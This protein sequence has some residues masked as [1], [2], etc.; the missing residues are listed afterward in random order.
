MPAKD[1]NWD[2]KKKI[3]PGEIYDV[4]PTK[5]K[6]DYTAIAKSLQASPETKQKALALAA[7]IAAHEELIASL[8]EQMNLAIDKRDND[9][10]YRDSLQTMNDNVL[11]LFSYIETNCSDAV[12]AMVANKQ[13]LFRG[14]N[15][16]KSVFIG[17]P[18]ENRKPKDSSVKDQQLFDELL[19]IAGFTAL[20][21]NSI[22][23]TASVSHASDFGN[24]YIIFPMNGFKF[25]WSPMYKD[26]IIREHSFFDIADNT[27]QIEEYYDSAAE[28]SRRIQI[29]TEDE[30]AYT[31][32]KSPGIA[33]KIKKFLAP[34]LSTFA[35]LRKIHYNYTGSPLNLTKETAVAY[36][37]FYDTCRQYSE[38]PNLPDS[39]KKQ[40]NVWI[41]QN[42]DLAEAAKQ[43]AAA[44]IDIIKKK[45]AN[46]MVTKH[47]FTN[48]NFGAALNV[49]NEIY[50][51]GKYVAID[52]DEFIDDALQYFIKARNKKG[53]K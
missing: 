31:H 44:N 16:T 33:S 40:F 50:V 35:E 28:F 23:C 2:F 41:K 13:L 5:I 45:L 37:L 20:R 12:A 26:V 21:S 6:V 51:L 14:M 53:K 25:T 8:R 36:L 38:I 27:E 10:I 47:K 43:D 48:T 1:Q 17:H 19:T 34:L 52:Y 42:G 9:V 39:I 15:I 32:S 46:E 7:S 24:T 22:F 30:I 11:K 18:K 3:S 4:D 49:K 29:G